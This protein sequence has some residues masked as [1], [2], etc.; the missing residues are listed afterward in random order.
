M[1]KKAKIRLLYEVEVRDKNGK[2]LSK[3]KRESQSLL[4]AFLKW[5]YTW[6]TTSD[7]AV[8]GSTQTLNDTGNQGRTIPYTGATTYMGR[9]GGWLGLAAQSLNGI[10]VGSGTTAVTPADPALVTQLAQGTGANQLV[11]GAQSVEAV[12]VV[13][14]VSSVRSTR[15]FT[16]NSAGAITVREIGWYWV[17]YDTG[18]AVRYF[19]GARDVLVTPQTV[20]IGATLTVR[21]TF[22]VTA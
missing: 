22:S 4:T 20:P 19:C 9:L 15:T 10:V 17:Q 13:A 1:T 2:I 18:P 11:H 14:L 16:N 6:L 5:L 12:S 21:Y 8:G 3:E 7:G